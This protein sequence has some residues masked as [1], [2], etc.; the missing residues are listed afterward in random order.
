MSYWDIPGSPV[1]PSQGTKSL[2]ATQHAKINQQMSYWGYT[3]NKS[4]KWTQLYMCVLKIEVSLL[5]N[6][7][8]HRCIT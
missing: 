3:K 1:L 2:H 8:R 7:T 5:F 4:D 6:S